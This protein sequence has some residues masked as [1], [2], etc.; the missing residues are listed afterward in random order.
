MQENALLSL[1]P[2]IW[3]IDGWMG[4]AWM[5]GDEVY[6]ARVMPTVANIADKSKWEFYAGGHGADAK[7]VTGDISGAQPLVDWKNHTGVVTMTYFAPIKKYV[8]SISTA[9]SESAITSNQHN[10]RH[11]FYTFK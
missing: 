10:T 2:E 7:W 9:T 3:L 5:L 6:M 8:L 1:A 4:Q 11:R